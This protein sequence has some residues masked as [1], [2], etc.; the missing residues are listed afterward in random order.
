VQSPTDVHALTKHLK[1]LKADPNTIE[2]LEKDAPKTNLHRNWLSTNAL[3]QINDCV[4]FEGRRG[5]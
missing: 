2:L 1:V 5:P 4:V 3:M